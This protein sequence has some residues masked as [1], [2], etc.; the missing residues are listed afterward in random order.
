MSFIVLYSLLLRLRAFL[1]VSLLV[2]VP[3][4]ALAQ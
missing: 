4:V 1:I 2:G 3:V